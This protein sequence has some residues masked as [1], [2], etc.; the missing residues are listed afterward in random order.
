MAQGLLQEPPL[1]VAPGQRRGRRLREA[2]AVIVLPGEAVG[3]Q[4]ELKR[5]RC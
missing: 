1:A 3:Q 4:V 5:E 2:T